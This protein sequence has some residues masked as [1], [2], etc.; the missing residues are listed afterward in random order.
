M[1]KDFLNLGLSYTSKL[2]FVGLKVRLRLGS[3]IKTN[4]RPRFR[5][6][7]DLQIP[8]FILRLF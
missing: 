5:K 3:V 6:S 8:S 2:D 1:S 4:S 7:L